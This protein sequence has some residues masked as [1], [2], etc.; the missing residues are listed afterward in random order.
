MYKLDAVKHKEP[1]DSSSFDILGK[2][3]ELIIY[4]ISNILGLILCGFIEMWKMRK[5]RSMYSVLLV[6]LLISVI[7]HAV[8]DG[9]TQLL[10][11]LPY[12]IFLFLMGIKN[13]IFLHIA[14]SELKKSNS[15][16][17]NYIITTHKNKIMKYQNNKNRKIKWTFL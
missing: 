4:I 3:Y 15:L 5:S 6:I 1:T 9:Y 7:I 16:N 2:L 14:K 8:Y 11:L 10:F 12:P 17:D 13:K